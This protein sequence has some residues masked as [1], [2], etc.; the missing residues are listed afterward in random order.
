LVLGSVPLRQG[1]HACSFKKLGIP[2]IRMLLHSKNKEIITESFGQSFTIKRK[3]V[4]GRLWAFWIWV[5][6]QN[7]TGDGP[8]CDRLVNFLSAHEFALLRILRTGCSSFVGIL[9]MILQQSANEDTPTDHERRAEKGR[10]MMPMP[11]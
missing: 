3:Y 4:M 11:L 7:P 1:E 6:D 5:K 9:C 8:K 10:A 2:S